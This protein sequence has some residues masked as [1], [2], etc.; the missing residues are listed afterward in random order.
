M[1]EYVDTPY[2]LVMDGDYTYDPKDIKHMLLH[3][4]NYDEIIGVR[5][6]SENIGWL[7][8]LGNKLINFTFNLLLSARLSYVCSCL[9][10]TSDAAD[11]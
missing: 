4:A 2:M 8:R 6:G 10:Y 5:S 7:H 1:L 11:E 3:A 9:L